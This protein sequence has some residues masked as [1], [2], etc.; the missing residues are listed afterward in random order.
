MTAAEHFA[1]SKERALEY[2]NKGDAGGAMSSFIQ[3]LANHEG[4]SGIL[5]IDL[6]GLFLGEVM[7]DGVVGARRFIN[8]LAG[9]Q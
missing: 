9:P 3:D 8:G 5:D 7:I 1:W 6:Q 4:T 2:V